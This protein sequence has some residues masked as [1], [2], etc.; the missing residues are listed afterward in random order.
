MC[1]DVAGLGNRTHPQP[2]V[3]FKNHTLKPPAALNRRRNITDDL[4]QKHAPPNIH[5]IQYDR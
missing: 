3:L 4:I 1:I 2:L 5:L